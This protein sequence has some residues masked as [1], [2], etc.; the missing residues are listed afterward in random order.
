MKSLDARI[1]YYLRKTNENFTDVVRQ[2]RTQKKRRNARLVA[3]KTELSKRC[4]EH[5]NGGFYNA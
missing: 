2:D 1:A 5:K 3:Y 4:T